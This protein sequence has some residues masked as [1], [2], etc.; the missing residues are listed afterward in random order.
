MSTEH[1]GPY[2]VHKDKMILSREEA[3]STAKRVKGLTSYKCKH[4]GGWHIAH[5]RSAMRFQRSRPNNR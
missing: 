1:N 4:C 3:A 2:C 5:K